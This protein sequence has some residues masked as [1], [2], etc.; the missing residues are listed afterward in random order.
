[1]PDTPAPMAD[2]ATEPDV[3]PDRKPALALLG[4]SLVSGTLLGAL[5]YAI[6]RPLWAEFPAGGLVFAVV[7]GLLVGLACAPFLMLLL[8]TRDIDLARPFVLWTCAV[9]V[10][11]LAYYCPDSRVFHLMGVSGGVFII[12]AGVVRCLLARV[13]LDTGLCRFCGY[14]LCASLPFERCPE[15]GRPF[16]KPHWFD[17]ESPDY[18]R[19]RATT[20][21]LAFVIRHPAVPV[22]AV[23]FTLLAS[24]AFLGLRRQARCELILRGIEEARRT[25]TAFDLKSCTH[26][27]WDAVY[28]FG[29]YGGGTSVERVVGFRWPD[30]DK[31]WDEFDESLQ[32]LVFVKGQTVVEYVTIP[33]TW[34]FSKAPY[35]LRLSRDEAVFEL[36]PTEFKTVE[37]LL[38]HPRSGP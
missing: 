29:P 33:R 18:A 25:G 2:A 23:A 4:F 12:T 17:V 38:A 20:R 26:F 10:G 36:R 15:C 6:G 1:M 31:A 8:R 9:I 21:L 24:Y 30:A 35:E 14:D 27:D 22:L 34:D 32:A 19:R 16:A 11:V 3:P 37:M 7:F 5:A 28:V 13:W